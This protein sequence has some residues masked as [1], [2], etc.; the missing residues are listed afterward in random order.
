MQLFA[1]FE[2]G[3]LVPQKARC[4]VWPVLLPWWRREGGRLHVLPGLPAA[5]LRACGTREPVCI[6]VLW[7]K[8]CVLT[9]SVPSPQSTRMSFSHILVRQ[10]SWLLIEEKIL[11]I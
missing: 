2:M 3:F 5:P 9:R 11:G 7:G 8:G 10:T 1:V 4:D 6:Y